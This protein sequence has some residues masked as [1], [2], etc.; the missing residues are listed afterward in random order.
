MQEQLEV[1]AEEL[2]LEQLERPQGDFFGGGAVMQGASQTAHSSFVKKSFSGLG[3]GFNTAARHPKTSM[4]A[5]AGG[6]GYMGYRGRKG[7]QNSPFQSFE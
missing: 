5:A 4:A 6:I 7:N 3:R 2:F 1:L